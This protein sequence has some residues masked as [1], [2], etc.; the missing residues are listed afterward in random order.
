M[1]SDV[2]FP[3]D[4]EMSIDDAFGPQSSID[5]EEEGEEAMDEGSEAEE[6]RPSREKVVTPAP[7]AKSSLKEEQVASSSKENNSSKKIKERTKRIKNTI[8]TAQDFEELLIAAADLYD[9]IGVM[10][11]SGGVIVEENSKILGHLKDNVRGTQNLREEIQELA[12]KISL[13]AGKQ[14]RA[15]NS[16]DDVLN[17]FEDNIKDMLQTVDLKPFVQTVEKTVSHVVDNIPVNELNNGVSAI[18]AGVLAI[19]KSTK[20]FSEDVQTFHNNHMGARSELKAYHTQ[21]ID[22]IKEVK[23]AIQK[24]KFGYIFA[25]CMVGVLAG[26]VLGFYSSKPFIEDYLFSLGKDV[27]TKIAEDRYIR[28]ID[29]LSS[30]YSH[31][32]VKKGNK[33]YLKIDSDSEVLKRGDKMFVRLD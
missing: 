5:D 27:S 8:T 11:A 18:Q 21:Y 17:K 33:Y 26:A 4:D 23:K 29:T 28:K 9:S 2:D 31:M 10:I 15:I 12:M 1:V 7:V 13:S 14:D 22:T 20:V 16:F 30:Q 24:N 25:S 19:T 32:F 6:E 3:D